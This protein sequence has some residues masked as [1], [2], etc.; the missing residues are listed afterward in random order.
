MIKKSLLPYY[1]SVKF[2]GADKFEFVSFVFNYFRSLLKSFFKTNLVL[3]GFVAHV[4]SLTAIGAII[5]GAPG[6]IGGP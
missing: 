3:G 2:V 5:G 4:G 1:L 6:G